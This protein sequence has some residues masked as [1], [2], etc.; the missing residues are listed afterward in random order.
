MSHRILVV[1]D[2]KDFVSLVQSAL[3]REGYEVETACN[4]KQG[5][6]KTKASR[7]DAI[8]LD[9]DMPEV[10]GG[11][12]AGDLR[13]E[14]STIPIIFL[15]QLLGPGEKRKSSWVGPWRMLPKPFSP[16][17]LLQM[18]REVLEERDAARK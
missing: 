16:D 1:D 5:Y 4:G 2:D 7:P 11:A 15:T 12:M 8:V 18:L 6:Q 13:D 3:E 10:D 9:V 17:A 14:G